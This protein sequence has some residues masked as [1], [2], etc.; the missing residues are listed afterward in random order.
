LSLADPN[1][2]A[3]K[4]DFFKVPPIYSRNDGNGF[5][6]IGDDD[7]LSR[8][9]PEY[10]RRFAFKFP[11]VDETHVDV[12]RDYKCNSNIATKEWFVKKYFRILTHRHPKRLKTGR[13]TPL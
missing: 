7:I 6:V 2:A 10:F 5:S 3:A 9:C 13:K 12:L 1:R 11:D 8:R 4:T